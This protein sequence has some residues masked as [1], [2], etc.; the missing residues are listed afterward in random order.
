VE[1]TNR[2]DRT[3]SNQ[4]DF[5]TAAN[6]TKIIRIFFCFLFKRIRSTLRSNRKDHLIR[7]VKCLK[8]VSFT[9]GTS[10]FQFGL[11]FNFVHVHVLHNFRNSLGRKRSNQIF[12]FA[13]K[14]GLTHLL[15]PKRSYDE[16]LN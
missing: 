12:F 15:L 8:T 10:N 11:I 3:R 9:V 7:F 13:F 6:R 1:L 5:V 16:F 2:T 14:L 4:L